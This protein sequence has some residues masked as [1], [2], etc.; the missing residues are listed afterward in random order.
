MFM[1]GGVELGLDARNFLFAQR[2]DAKTVVIGGHKEFKNV[3]GKVTENVVQ[4]VKLI[5]RSFISSLLPASNDVHHPSFGSKEY[6]FEEVKNKLR[7]EAY[8]NIRQLLSVDD[9]LGAG[10]IKT[11][12]KETNNDFTDRSAW[13]ADDYV[14]WEGKTI[15]AHMALQLRWGDFSDKPGDFWA[16]P[17]LG[18]QKL[19]SY[20]TETWMRAHGV[21]AIFRGHQHNGNYLTGLL[22]GGGFFDAWG[23]GS[24]QTIISGA[25]MFGPRRLGDAFAVLGMT[26]DAPATWKLTKCTR[27]PDLPSALPRG[28]APPKP[29][30]EKLTCSEDKGWKAGDPASRRKQSFGGESS[31]DE[32]NIIMKRKGKSND[33]RKAEDEQQIDSSSSS[34]CPKISMPGSDEED[35]GRL[36]FSKL[37]SQRI[38]QRRTSKGDSIHMNLIKAG[39]DDHIMQP[40]GANAIQ[41]NMI[42][43]RD[44]LDKPQP[45]PN[46]IQKGPII[47]Q[48]E[49]QQRD[50]RGPVGNQQP[51]P[52]ADALLAVVREYC[53]NHPERSFHDAGLGSFRCILTW[54]QN[55]FTAAEN[56]D[57][58]GTFQLPGKAFL[59]AA[60]NIEKSNQSPRQGVS[61]IFHYTNSLRV[62]D[63]GKRAR[64]LALVV[65]DDVLTKKEKLQN[66]AVGDSHSAAVSLAWFDPTT[67]QDARAAFE[68]GA[69]ANFNNHV[70]ERTVYKKVPHGHKKTRPLFRVG[71]N[72]EFSGQHVLKAQATMC[73]DFLARNIDDKGKNSGKTNTGVKKKVKDACGEAT[74]AESPRGDRCFCFALRTAEGGTSAKLNVMRVL[75]R[76]PEEGERFTAKVRRKSVLFASSLPMTRCRCFTARCRPFVPRIYRLTQCSPHARSASTSFVRRLCNKIHPR[77]RKNRRT[78]SLELIAY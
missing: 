11:W 44:S 7:C 64:H 53:K 32:D 72:F 67:A 30:L 15:F 73:S 50:I 65:A 10:H 60:L 75:F 69:K 77:T 18:R 46:I 16:M 68:K 17:S 43:R 58:D 52:D 5:D 71:D 38:Q 6:L 36:F 37:S 2:N 39:T 21:A 63:N 9:I 61:W 55:G 33:Q 35:F 51:P 3:G 20:L 54:M 70:A 76:T 19:G 23:T 27:A 26:G 49:Q 28:T 22:N 57:H 47:N 41:S 8:K 34:R 1:H 42:I 59:A 48:Q 74:A 78:Y 62:F 66:L 40:G 45:Q 31:D 13:P 14:E 4:V 24:V 56:A 12:K 29:T 25:N